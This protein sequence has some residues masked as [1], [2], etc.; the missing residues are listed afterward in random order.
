MIILNVSPNSVPTLR[1]SYG[2][3]KGRCLI[4][5]LTLGSL[6][7][8]FFSVNFRVK[9]H[10][11]NVEF[12][13][14]LTAQARTKSAPRFHFFPVNFCVKWLLWNVEVHVDCAGPHKSLHRGFGARHFFS[15][16]FSVKWHLGNVENKCISTAQARTKSAPRF[17][18]ADGCGIFPINFRIKLLLWNAEMYFDC[19]VSHKVWSAGLVC[20]ILPVNFC[21]S[22]SCEIA[23]HFDC[24]GSH[25]VWS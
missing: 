8:V 22:G 5:V 18:G 4:R 15:V 1:G 17:W 20:G 19:G 10:L 16:N 13:R 24:A 12:K 25:K 2:R 3:C 6:G 14:I 11:W 23:V 21:K 9:W 7:C